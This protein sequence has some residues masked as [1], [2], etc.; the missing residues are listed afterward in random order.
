MHVR[1][2]EGVTDNFLELSLSNQNGWPP[3][4]LTTVLEFPHAE[5]GSHVKLFMTPSR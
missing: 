3:Y 1:V 2:E 5:D 4:L